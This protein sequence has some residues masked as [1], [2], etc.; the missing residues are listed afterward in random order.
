MVAMGK[1]QLR[2]STVIFVEQSRR[3]E[4]AS[5]TR[6]TLQRLEP[7]LGFKMKVV[8]NAGTS[9]GNLLSNKKP[10]DRKQVWKDQL[11]PLQATFRE[12]GG[13]QDPEHS[14]RVPVHHVQWRGEGEA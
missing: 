11:P 6:E 9:L 5:K 12:G 10:L 7:L 8:E 14:V 3:G 13:L 2:V 4:L 1:E